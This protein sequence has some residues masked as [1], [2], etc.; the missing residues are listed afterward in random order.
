MLVL[1]GAD[2][3]NGVVGAED[4]AHVRR[5]VPLS[6]LRGQAGWLGR[7]RI[8]QLVGE[9]LDAVVVLQAFLANVAVRTDC[10]AVQRRGALLG[11][12]CQRLREQGQ[13]GHKEQYALAPAGQSLGDLQ[14]G[15]RLARATCHD[16]LTA[17]GGL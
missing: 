10:K 4:H 3:I 15:E 7:G 17:V 12:L 5:V 1:S 13:A 14:A 11:S 6:H 9:G 8:A 2:D 16:N